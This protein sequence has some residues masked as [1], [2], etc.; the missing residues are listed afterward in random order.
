MW[1]NYSETDSG[2]V[3]LEA[4]V[5]NVQGH[6]ET[7]Y[8]KRPSAEGKMVY[9]YLPLAI[10][11]RPTLSRKDMMVFSVELFENEYDS[12][13]LIVGDYDENFYLKGKVDTIKVKDNHAVLRFVVEK[14][15]TFFVRGFVWTFQT[16]TFED[17]VMLSETLQSSLHFEEKY[18]VL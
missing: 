9:T 11:L 17:S 3:M 7:Y 6:A 1:Q 8:L 15:G 18:K 5:L 13:F 4:G 2:K 14:S 10:S 16:T 12:A